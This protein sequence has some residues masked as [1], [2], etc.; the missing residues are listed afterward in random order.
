MYQP[1]SNPPPSPP[2]SG[3]WFDNAAKEY[4]A[5]HLHPRVCFLVP[6]VAGSESNQRMGDWRGLAI[7]PDGDLWVAGKWTA[8]KAR[9]RRLG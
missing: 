4:M 2:N 3:E 9:S 6:C 5:D 8:G 7:A 1:A